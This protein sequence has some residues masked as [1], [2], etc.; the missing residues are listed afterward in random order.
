MKAVGV[1]LF[2]AGIA[3]GNN[4]APAVG[5]PCSEKL[6]DLDRRLELNVAKRSKPRPTNQPS[7]KPAPAPRALPEQRYDAPLALA[8]Q[9]D[10]E[11]NEDCHKA[12]AE[13]EMLISQ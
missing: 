5:G 11:G 3:L 8:R 2:A 4:I 10:A 12:V 13:V 9:L 6:A 1:T 7:A